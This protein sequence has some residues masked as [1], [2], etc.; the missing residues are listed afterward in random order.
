MR[1]SSQL[2]RR[3]PQSEWG[4]PS[5]SHALRRGSL[6]LPA[7]GERGIQK[8][9]CIDCSTSFALKMNVTFCDFV[10]QAGEELELSGC[11]KSYS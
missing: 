7:C 8:L 10:G 6:P 1:G 3:L 4:R 9:I 2:L 11:G 5:P